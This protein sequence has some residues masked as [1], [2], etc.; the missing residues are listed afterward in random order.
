MNAFQLF[1]EQ[2]SSGA[3]EVD[4]L[5]FG[6][7]AVTGFYFL[8]V[9]LPLVYFSVR[10][11]VGS[12]ASRENPA[13]G[14]NLIEAS[15]TIIP[16]IMSLGLF[17]W[18]AAVYF[19]LRKAPADALRVNVVAKQWM[20]KLQHAEGKREINELHIPIGRAVRLIMTSQDV[21]HSFFVPAFRAK[22]DV[23]PGTYTSEWFKPTRA[24]EYHL[25]CAEYCGTE[26][27]QMI[28]RVVVMQPAEYQRWLTVGNVDVSMV[29]SGRRLFTQLGC[30]GCHMGSGSVRAPRLEGI[31]GKP[32]PVQGDG[33]V[34]ADERYIRDSILM[35][36]AQIS[37]GYENLMP[38]FK[39]H[40]TESDLMQLIEYLRI[41]SADAP[42][43]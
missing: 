10:Y 22:Q 14:S 3:R 13:R 7:V 34:V 37:A 28:G 43:P 18:G 12:K 9:F 36:A 32:V 39:G 27:S 16:A 6:L 1:P 42:R 20:W 24:G 30:S 8:I 21:I 17:G 35:P 2:A 41:L 25:F 11:R 29:E 26:H 5:T 23:I 31:F 33:F 19:H 40:I 38:T 4:W 15:W